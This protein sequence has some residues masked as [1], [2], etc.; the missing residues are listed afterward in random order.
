M[1]F[2]LCFIF[3]KR[4]I[5]IIS[6][7]ILPLVSLGFIKALVDYIRPSSY[8]K[9]EIE[10]IE[11]ED[12]PINEHTEENIQDLDDS[13]KIDSPIISPV[14]TGRKLKDTI[15]YDIDPTKIP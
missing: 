13:E 12:E 15:Y 6:G 7:A 3:K 8:K 14:N 5:A 10:E 4:V 1:V 2:I 9:P 11:T